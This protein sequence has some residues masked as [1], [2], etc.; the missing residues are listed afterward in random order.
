MRREF[1]HSAPVVKVAELED[2]GRAK[3]RLLG[4]GV[5]DPWMFESLVPRQP[6]GGVDD[7]EA[8]NQ[9]TGRL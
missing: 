1:V 7:K 8:S 4:Q 5:L 9:V 6:L 3:V 2:V